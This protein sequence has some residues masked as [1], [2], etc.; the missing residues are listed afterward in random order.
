LR[1]ASARAGSANF[2]AMPDTQ[3][4]NVRVNRNSIQLEGSQLSRMTQLLSGILGWPVIDRTGLT[5][6]YNASLTWGDAP[7]TNGDVIAS[8]APAPTTDPHHESIFTAIQDQL[9]LSLDSQ[10]APIDTLVIHSMEMSSANE[11]AIAK[12]KLALF[13]RSPADN[14]WLSLSR[15]AVPNL[16]KLPS[17]CSNSVG[18]WPNV[19]FFTKLQLQSIEKTLSIGH[20]NCLACVSSDIV[21][22]P[23]PVD[24]CLYCSELFIK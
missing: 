6:S 5:G 7:V 12:P 16:P 18:F 15:R 22:L 13:F 24:V 1:F 21:Q 19:N 8:T 20:N 14:I 17:R 11:Q 2:A 9:D 3:S 4:S 23:C 10:R